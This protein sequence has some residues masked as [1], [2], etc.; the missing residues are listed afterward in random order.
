[1]VWLI[2]SWRWSTHPFLLSI[3]SFHCTHLWLMWEITT[4]KIFSSKFSSWLRIPGLLVWFWMTFMWHCTSHKSA[5]S[6]TWIF[7][8][9]NT[10]YNFHCSIINQNLL[11]FTQI[12][13]RILVVSH[14]SHAARSEQSYDIAWKCLDMFLHTVC[15][16]E[17]FMCLNEDSCKHISEISLELAHKSS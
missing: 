1:M 4:Y 10:M 17:V 11:T 9:L 7:R 2:G 12:Y 6:M 8:T 3:T 13:C 16:M 15:Y 14:S 5:T